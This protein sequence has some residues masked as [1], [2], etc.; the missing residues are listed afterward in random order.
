MSA[1]DESLAQFG[2]HLS[3]LTISEQADEPFGN[4]AT[5]AVHAD[6]ELGKE[7]SDVAPAMHLSTNYRYPD[8]GA[9]EPTL[10][11]RACTPS[12]AD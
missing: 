5:L 4:L 8:D 10:D 11:G 6:D 12:D 3:R 9:L 2:Q 7:L 1:D